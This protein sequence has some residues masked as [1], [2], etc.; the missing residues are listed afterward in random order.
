MSYCTP[1]RATLRRGRSRSHR[2]R[3]RRRAVEGP[4]RE[5][6]GDEPYVAL[7]DPEGV[8]NVAGA[9]TVHVT[10]RGIRY[11]GADTGTYVELRDQQGVANVHY[12]IPLHV[13]TGEGPRDDLL[14]GAIAPAAPVDDVELAARVEAERAH[15]ER[16]A[17]KEG[18]GVIL[19]GP[20]IAA[21]EAP[22]EAAAEVRGA[23]APAQV[24]QAAAPVREA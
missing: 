6:A 12:P 15:V 24:G 10:Q 14:D 16:A 3:R 22:D 20:G 17:G 23:G 4:T 2:L 19:R 1:S 13:P 11:C 21:A 5:G 8:A 7:G 9:I 18:R